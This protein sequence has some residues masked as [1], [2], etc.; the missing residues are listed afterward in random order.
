MTAPGDVRE[1]ARRLREQAVRRQREAESRSREIRSL[2]GLVSTPPLPSAP[3]HALA[4]RGCVFIRQ[5]FKGSR[6]K[7]VLRALIFCARCA[8]ATAASG[9]GH[10]G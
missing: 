9:G 7:N 2:V 10:G 6:I 8:G 4:A 3:I 5:V 1:E